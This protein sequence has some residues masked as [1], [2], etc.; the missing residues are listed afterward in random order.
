MADLKL[1][2]A[3]FIG[4]LRGGGNPVVHRGEELRSDDA[5]IDSD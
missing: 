2:G 4:T 1:A 3:S 5:I